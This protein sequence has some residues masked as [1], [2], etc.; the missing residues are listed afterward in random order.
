MLVFIDESGDAG[1][2]I[3]RGS[4]PVFVVAMVIFDGPDE[5]KSTEHAIRM[6]MSRLRISSEFKF[7]ASRDQVRDEF[8]QAVRNC[9]FMVRAIVIRKEVIYSPNL[10]ADKENF[11]RFFVRQM[12]GHDNGLLDR[13][14]VFIDGSGDRAFRKTLTAY[15]RKHLGQRL[16]SLRLSES[17]RDVLIQ[18]ADMC[19]GAIARSY[20]TDR[21]NAAR[22]R[23]MLHPRI[24]DVWD[25]R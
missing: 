7:N 3:T 21:N 17:H 6:T 15:L 19:V 8:F 13:A 25:F 5:A 23:Q 16:N 18:L 20:R 22:W 12:M 10:M 11:Y 4:S 2:K 9:P 14:D 24:N 1:F